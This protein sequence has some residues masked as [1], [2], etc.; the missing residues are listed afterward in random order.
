MIQIRHKSDCALHNAPVYEL[1]P[2]DCGGEKAM[3]SSL[4]ELLR[5]GNNLTKAIDDKKN[6]TGFNADLKVGLVMVRS[7]LIEEKEDD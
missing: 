2:C 4:V 7:A 1:K 3:L 5:R 6:L